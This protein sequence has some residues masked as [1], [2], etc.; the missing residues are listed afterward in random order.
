VC[1]SRHAQN[2]ESGSLM[3]RMSRA[4]LPVVAGAKVSRLCES[5]KNKKQQNL[6]GKALSWSCNFPIPAAP[7][8]MQR[9]KSKAFFEIFSESRPAIFSN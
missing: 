6:G 1:L 3:R 7:N 9:K 5:Q 8:A 4:A 2:R